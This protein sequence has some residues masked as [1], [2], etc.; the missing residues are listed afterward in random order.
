[1]SLLYLRSPT[2]PLYE[3]LSLDFV[4]VRSPTFGA[5]PALA[6][7]VIPRQV[8]LMSPTGHTILTLRRT[9][10]RPAH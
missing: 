5:Y 6:S 3:C 4:C 9:A 8:K 2:S 7:K 10:R 1:M